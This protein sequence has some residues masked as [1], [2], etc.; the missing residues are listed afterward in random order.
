MLDINQITDWCDSFW[1]AEAS[2]PFDQDTLV[3]KTFGK[4]FAI[5]PLERDR[6]LVVK[7]APTLVEE[8]SNTYSTISPAWHMNKKYWISIQYQTMPWKMIETL[9]GHSYYNVLMGLP[10]RI[11]LQHP[12]ITALQI[13]ANPEF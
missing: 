2:F 3:Y 7:C 6:E 5:L 10:L 1:G 11:R 13:Y 8:L 4:I 9:I 12:D